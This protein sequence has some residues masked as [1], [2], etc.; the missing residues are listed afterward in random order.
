MTVE[1]RWVPEDELGALLAWSDAVVLSHREASQSGV[2]ASAMAARR[3]LIATRVG[4]LEEQ[5]RG[6]P[7]ALLCDPEPESIAA[8]IRRLL[9]GAGPPSPP[10]AGPAADWGGVAASMVQGIGGLVRR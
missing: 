2:A 7:M 8:A 1:N 10:I 4:G 3:W 9:E 6:E 5:L